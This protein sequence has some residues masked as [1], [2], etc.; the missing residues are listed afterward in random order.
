MSHRGWAMEQTILTIDEVAE[1][2]KL[3]PSSVY[4]LTRD[5]S[6]KRQTHPIPYMRIAGKLRFSREALQGWLLKMQG[7]QAA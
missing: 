6:Q 4:E 1:M 3:K 7:G 5:R 2:L